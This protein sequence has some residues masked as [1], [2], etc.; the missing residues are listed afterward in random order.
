MSKIYEHNPDTGITYSRECGA[1]PRTRLPV[2]EP[3]QIDVF[4]YLQFDDLK[5]TA[6]TNPALQK[7]F[8][9][10]ITLYYIIKDEQ[11]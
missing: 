10:L 3:A 1:D 5:D 8:D 2:K 11:R 6:K 4:D 9:N 7:A